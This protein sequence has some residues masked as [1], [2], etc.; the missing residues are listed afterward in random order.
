MPHSCA[1]LCIAVP[2]LEERFSRS[3][4]VIRVIVVVDR[5]VKLEGLLEAQPFFRSIDK[6]NHSYSITAV[7]RSE[8][9]GLRSLFE[10]VGLQWKDPKRRLFAFDGDHWVSV[11]TLC[12]REKVTGVLQPSSS[13]SALFNEFPSK[14]GSR[15]LMVKV[16]LYLLAVVLQGAELD[17]SSAAGAASNLQQLRLTINQDRTQVNLYTWLSVNQGV[18]NHCQ[19][20]GNQGSVLLLAVHP[21]VRARVSVVGYGC[22][23][24]GRVGW[25]PWGGAGW[26]LPLIRSPL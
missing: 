7:G 8:A 23:C 22:V 3:N 16:A 24:W 25:G 9:Q 19:C 2:P 20:V 17:S 5:A 6:P 26:E 14:I 18:P 21:H 13:S 4:S 1:D 12:R 10:E 11:D 15:L